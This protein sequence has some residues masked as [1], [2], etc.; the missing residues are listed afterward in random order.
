[1]IKIIAM[2]IF[3]ISLTAS[4]QTGISNLT[5]LNSTKSTVTVEN[6]NDGGYYQI[7][8]KGKKL[9]TSLNIAET[10]E[11]FATLPYKNGVLYVVA[12]TGGGR[13]MEQYTYIY[14]VFIDKTGNIKLINTK[15][16]DKQTEGSDVINCSN[17]HSKESI[18][19]K[20]NGENIEITCSEALTPRKTR[21]IYWHLTNG[22]FQESRKSIFQ[23]I[24]E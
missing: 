5:P 10:G 18:D 22:I 6:R 13:L 21:K 17:V 12:T 8:V 16:L 15:E 7:Y 23:G 14:T 1:M 4:A 9:D 24:R 2:S 19:L 11:V 20:V 3:L